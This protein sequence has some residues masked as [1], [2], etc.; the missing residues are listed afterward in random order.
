[1]E[2]GEFMPANRI[3]L[4]AALL[5]CLIASAPGKDENPAMRHRMVQEQI[6]A[7]G[8]RDERVLSA[9][10]TV[11][12]HLFV[13]PDF[14]DEAHADSPLPI[15]EGQTISQP[16]I[17]ALMSELAEI[18]PGEKVLEIGTG[19][20]Y[21]A[22]VLAELGAEVW[23]IEIIPELGR[24]A[25]ENLAAAGYDSLHLRVGDGYAGWPEAAPFDAVLLT[26][27]PREIPQPLIDQLAEGGVLVAPVGGWHQEL[28]QIRKISGEL[29]RRRV[30]PVRFVP[31]TGK[32]LKGP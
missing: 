11:P 19:S 21:A 17:V 14:T 26:A 30:I 8:V 3:F 7:R 13:D 5:A 28:V 23:S 12:R 20:G 27:A 32:A 31:M 25:R 24:L 22:A 2:G 4:A 16:Y 9:M 6:R 29:K 10:E 15:G 1:M 18:A